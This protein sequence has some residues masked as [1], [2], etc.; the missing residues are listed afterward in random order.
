MVEYTAKD[1][2]RFWSKVNKDGPV[3]E[4]CP[5]LG[6]CWIWTA[7]TKRGYGRIGVKY[8]DYPTHRVS[9]ELAFGTIQ[10][11]LHVLHKCDNRACCNPQHLTLG[12][13]LD[14]MRDRDRKGRGKWPR[15][16]QCSQCK[17]SDAQVAEA[18]Q[19]YAHG[20]RQQHIA[21]D[22]HVSRSLIGQ[23]VTYKLR[24]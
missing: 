6:P 14:N 16:E 12:T 17:L 23:L 10:D 1:V 4:H 8:H 11:G 24:P 3:P 20:E 21:D 22:M 18:R 13:P 19:R 9:W 7:S 5:E 2:A 15:G